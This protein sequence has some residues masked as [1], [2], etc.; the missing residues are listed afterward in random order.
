MLL[1][2]LQQVLDE[3]EASRFSRKRAWENL[4]ELR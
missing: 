4:Q 3:L 2:E 1:Q